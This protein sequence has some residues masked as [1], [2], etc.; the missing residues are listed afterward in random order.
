M[1][2]PSSP[3]IMEDA[4]APVLSARAELA[5]LFR[6]AW[7]CLLGLIISELVVACLRF[8]V[9]DHLGALLNMTVAG[10]GLFGLIT[11][12]LSGVNP[13]HFV[14][15]ATVAALSGALDFFTLFELT[16]RTQDGRHKDSHGK[17]PYLEWA[18]LFASAM[19]QITSSI[20][21][22][23]IWRDSEDQEEEA[24]MQSVPIA[25]RHALYRAVSNRGDVD[26]AGMLC[27]AK[28]SPAN[29]K[30]R[31]YRIV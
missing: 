26:T 1:A 21:A 25:V 13:L 22:Y 29:F 16:M 9:H 8:M 27:G 2:T 15:Y 12:H 6:C 19:A 24:Q 14:Y 7:R 11:A 18:V 3:T 31:A 5:P 10:I 28:D 30:G 20:V 23:V 4:P 17:I